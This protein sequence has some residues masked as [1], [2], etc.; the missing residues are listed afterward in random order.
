M[1]GAGREPARPRRVRYGAAAL[2]A[3]ASLGAFQRTQCS[4]I[5]H[6]DVRITEYRSVSASYAEFDMA[7]NFEMDTGE[8]LTL[9]SFYTQQEIDQLVDVAMT[10]KRMSVV[11]I[12]LKEDDLTISSNSASLLI[13]AKDRLQVRQGGT[14]MTLSV[15]ISFTGGEFRIQ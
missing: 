6:T 8:I 15:D 11:N 13:A 14:S 10:E 1:R 5:M 9:Q 2:G 4:F 12:P 3:A 7:L